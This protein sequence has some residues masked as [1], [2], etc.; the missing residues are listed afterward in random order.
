MKKKLGV[1]IC[2]CGG[3]ISDYVDVEKYVRPLNTKR[4]SFW[5]KPPCLHVRTVIRRK[6]WKIFINIIGW[7]HSGFLLS[8]TAFGYL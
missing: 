8:K 3:N 1:Y 2:H 6:W 7:S 5:L 4:V